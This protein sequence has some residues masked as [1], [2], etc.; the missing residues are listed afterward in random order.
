MCGCQTV[1]SDELTRTFACMQGK[2]DDVSGCSCDLVLILIVET[3]VCDHAC[4]VESVCDGGVMLCAVC[5]LGRLEKGEQAEAKDT[6]VGR[7]RPRDVVMAFVAR[8]QTTDL[9]FL[10]TRLGQP[11]ASILK[12]THDPLRSRTGRI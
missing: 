10:A 1:Q 5:S 4:S 3:L 8:K 6:P 11:I 7:C 2:L 9:A 12:T